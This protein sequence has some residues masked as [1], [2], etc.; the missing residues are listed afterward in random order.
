MKKVITPKSK[1][2]T[3]IGQLASLYELFR[4]I[5]SSEELNFNLSELR[6]ANPL[7]ILPIS[8][9]INTTD[10]SFS[11][12][13]SSDVGSYLSA[14]NFPMGVDTVSEFQKR[15]QEGKSYI[16]ISVLKKEAGAAR[17]RLESSFESMIYNSLD[18]GNIKGVSNAIYYPISELVTNIFEHSKQEKGFI[19]GQYYPKKNFLDICIVDRGRGLAGSYKEEK[20]LILT[21]DKAIEEVMRGNSTKADK[22]RGYG[23]RTSKRVVCEGLGGEFVLL[24][25]S[26]ALVSVGKKEN[27]VSLP[28]FN[29]RGVILAYRIPRP[30]T[31]IDI[32]PYLE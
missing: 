7:L 17:E 2:S 14:I 23:V 8:A 22:E 18:V 11:I 9:Y 3:L 6:W 20:S 1:G 5:N 31:P 15:L 19:F 32:S 30:T 24:S 28:D 12:N 26:T 25:G 16:P 10:S 21:D 29:W 27:L 13:N 4:G